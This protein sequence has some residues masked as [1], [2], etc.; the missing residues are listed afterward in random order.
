MCCCVEPSLHLVVVEMWPLPLGFVAESVEQLVGEP[1]QHSCLS[2]DGLLLYWLVL[3]L[4]WIRGTGSDSGMCDID[5]K[6]AR[7]VCLR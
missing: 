4:F 1:L 5:R 7:V 6:A 3:S 2:G